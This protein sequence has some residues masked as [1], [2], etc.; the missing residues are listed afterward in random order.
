MHHLQ[1][2]GEEKGELRPHDVVEKLARQDYNV[3]AT[4]GGLPLHS[5]KVPNRSTS[6]ARAEAIKILDEDQDADPQVQEPDTTEEVVLSQPLVVTDRFT[7]EWGQAWI[8]G[9]P[10]DEE[11][12]PSPKE[13]KIDEKLTSRLLVQVITT[14]GTHS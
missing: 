10:T 5:E 4:Q 3:M 7:R 6:V 13:I 11:A 14:N 9:A 8:A 2:G 12:E 1:A